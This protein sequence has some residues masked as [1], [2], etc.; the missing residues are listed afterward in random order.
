MPTAEV[1]CLEPSAKTSSLPTTTSDS[2]FTNGVTVIAALSVLSMV[3][4]A[5][6]MLPVLA[7]PVIVM[8]SVLAFV[9][10]VIPV[11][12]TSVRVSAVVSAV[13]DVCP[14]IAMVLNV[15]GR[16]LSAATG[17]HAPA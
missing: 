4:A 6:V 10:S 15:L 9:V 16:L 13:T 7:V 12:A 17:T 11:P 1:R 8:V 14:A 5:K 3:L 2:K